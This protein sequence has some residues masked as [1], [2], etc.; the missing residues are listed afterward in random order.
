MEYNKIFRDISAGLLITDKDFLVKWANKFEED[1]YG[2]SLEE[3]K[4]MWVV[5]C[6]RD[7]NKAFIESFLQKFKSGEM[8]E[9]TKIAAGMVITY[10]SYFENQ[11]FAGIVRT[12]I[13]MP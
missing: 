6:H 8:K 1:F 10:S 7:E 5:N 9:F 3:M 4:G 13:K 11:E 2:K 12:R